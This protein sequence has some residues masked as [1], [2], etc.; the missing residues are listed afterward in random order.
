MVDAKLN[1]VGSEVM[2]GTGDYTAAANASDEE[3]DDDDDD[4]KITEIRFVP[5][6][7]DSLDLMFQAMSDGNMLHP[8][9]DDSFSEDDE[10]EFEPSEGF[11]RSAGANGHDQA[12]DPS[13]DQSA[14]TCN[15]Y[16]FENADDQDEEPM[17]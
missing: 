2:N 16:Q 8:D 3:A 10:A 12:Q 1:D 11:I 17:T 7:V 6:K 9:E 13:I 15:D 14:V 4:S 5:A